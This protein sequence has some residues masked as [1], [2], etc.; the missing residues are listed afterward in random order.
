ML[1]SFLI[2]SYIEGSAQTLSILYSLCTNEVFCPP[3]FITKSSFLCFVS[4]YLMRGSALSC[5]HT[6][7]S[8][9]QNVP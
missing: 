3:E 5:L 2:G 8:Y 9:Y 7:F 4:C 1:L 6:G